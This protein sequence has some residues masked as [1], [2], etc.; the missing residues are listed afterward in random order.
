MQ[1]RLKD[2]TIAVTL[3]AVLFALYRPLPDLGIVLAAS[4]L[5]AAIARVVSRGQIGWLGCVG[6]SSLFGVF[7]WLLLA[8]PTSALK[9]RLAGIVI[10]ILISWGGCF[11][12][13]TIERD[14][15]G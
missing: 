13:G 4:L 8:F 3:V 10:P 5:G 9:F 2:L 6:I 12:V 14:L 15:S 11:Y 7:G 1:Y